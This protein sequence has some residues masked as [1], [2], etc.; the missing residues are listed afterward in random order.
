[1]ETSSFLKKSYEFKEDRKMELC[2][3]ANNWAYF[4]YKR[5]SLST[6]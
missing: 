4:Y 3:S 2:G 1:M 6:V 5:I